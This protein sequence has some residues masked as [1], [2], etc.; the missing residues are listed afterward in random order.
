MYNQDMMYYIRYAFN[1]IVLGLQY[2][3]LPVFMYHL[4]I[5]V[6]GLVKRKEDNAENFS[7]VNRFAVLVAAHNEQVVIG[8]IVR[9][10]KN[11][12]Y[13]EELYD[14]FVIADNCTD[15]TA[16]IARDN[17]AIAFE[18]FDKVKRGKGFAL[19]WMFDKIFKMEKHYDAITV[20]DADNLVSKNYLKEMNKH[21]C[22]G[23]KVIQGYL[24]SKN[25]FDSTIS[26]SYSLTYWLMNR[27]YQLPRYYLGLSCAIGGTGF[28]VSTEILKEIGWGA[29]SLTEDLEFTLKLVLSGNKVYWS[30]EVTIYDEKPITMAQSWKQRKRWM[31]GHTDCACRY[32]TKLF[33]KAIT[34]R[35][36]V[37]FDCSLYAIQPLIIVI[38]GASILLNV[39]KLIFFADIDKLLNWNTLWTVVIMIITTYISVVFILLEGKFTRKSFWHFVLYPFYNLTWVPIIIQGF[40]HRNEKEWSHTVHT[41]S[42]EIKDLQGL[43][44]AG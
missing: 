14:I 40:I 1:L 29:T 39:I 43:E 13:P 10:L 28:V 20:F 24:D 25:P 11:I 22:K 15:S 9:N 18:R 19:E 12:D 36:P 30:H 32:F 26:G 7:L 16:Q 34:K 27:M 17:G 41:R 8:N 37:A 33:K 23:H 35:D 44:R 2:A 21:L 31:Q 38:S 6:F 42:M 3:I 4:I 5:S